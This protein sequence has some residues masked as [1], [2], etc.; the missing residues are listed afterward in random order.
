VNKKQYE[1][2]AEFRYSI[3]KF[4]QFSEAAAH[5]AGIT[6]QQHQVLLAIK[7]YPGREWATVGELAERLCAGQTAVTN[8]VGRMEAGGL[9]ERRTNP[10]D[11]RSVTVHITEK[12]ERILSGLSQQHM[13]EL[14]RL[15]GQ[16]ITLI[17]EASQ[18][19]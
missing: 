11:R 1:A 12:G 7:G 14:N 8:L 9:L 19:E 16:A 5:E 2:I 18:A 15:R 6:P 13:S 3:R 17:P 10:R 4:L